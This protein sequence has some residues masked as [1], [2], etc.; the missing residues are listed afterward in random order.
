MKRRTRN[1]PY[2]DFRILTDFENL[3]EAH[4]SC[5]KGKLWKDS[6]AQ[7]DLRALESTLYLKYLLESGKYRMSKYHCFQVNER[8]KTRDIKSTQYKDRIVQKSLHENIIIPYIRPYLIY[9]TG[10]SLKDKGTD[11]QLERLKEQLEHF[12]QKYGTDGLFLVG[13]MYHF[14]DTISHS[15]LNSWYAAG[16]SDD[17]ILSLIRHI[18]ATI[19]GGVGVPLGNQLSQD[20]ALI[21]GSPMDHLVKDHFGVEGYGRYNDDFYA[22]GRTKDELKVLLKAIDSKAKSLGLE[23]NENK[24]KIVP[25]TTGI[26][27]LGFHIYVTKSGKVVMRIKAKAKS[28]LRKRLRKFKKKVEAG[29]M[30]YQDAKLGYQS[31]IAHYERGNTYYLRQEMDCY[32]YSLFEEYLNPEEKKQLKKLRKIK[33]YREW[34]RRSNNGKTSLKSSGGKQNQRHRDNVQRKTDPVDGHGTRSQRGS[35]REH[36]SRNQQHNK[37]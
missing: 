32:F 29:Q 34:K 24:T 16:F 12:I 31:S 20:D 8:G 35:I 17:L 7:Y 37:P 18:H 4:K 3:Y 15:W 10:A 33:K 11:F 23:L 1:N 27:F 21:A 14:F 22:L 28:R 13:D 25:M 30:T 26:N 5:R 19:P 2:D 6:A 36:S 9:D